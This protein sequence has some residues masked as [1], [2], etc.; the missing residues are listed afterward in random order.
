MTPQERDIEKLKNKIEDSENK[1][2][3][4]NQNRPLVLA[5]FGIIACLTFILGLSAGFFVM[6]LIMIL[7]AVVWSYLKSREL[8][9]LKQ[10]IFRY[11]MDIYRIE[12]KP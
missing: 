6:G 11:K 10:A 9:A 8:V 3:T 12:N 2:R 4:A 5:I 7:V 1:L